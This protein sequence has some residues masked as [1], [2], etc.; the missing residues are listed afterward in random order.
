MRLGTAGAAL[1]AAQLA[2]RTALAEDQALDALIGDTQRG[3]YGQSF[4]DASR[5]IHM[6][7][8]SEPTVSA[9]T[10]HTT[11]KAIEHYADVVG[12]GGWPQVPS[13][14]VLRLGDRSPERAGAPLPARGLRR[15]RSKRRRQR[16]LQF[17]RGGGGA[18]LSG[19]P[20]PLDRWSYSRGN[21]GSAQCARA[22]APRPT[23]S[24]PDSPSRL[25]HEFKSALRR[26]QFAGG[27][28]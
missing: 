7:T 9:A 4:D 28:H 13:V 27:A 26:L 15:H 25:E 1:A 8:P 6:P 5:T 19:P 17:L 3:Q 16:N 14:S 18:P 23:Q 20:W 11:E 22:G 24:Q 10:A 21:P 12:R 2:G